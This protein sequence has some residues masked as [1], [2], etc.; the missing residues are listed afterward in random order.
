MRTVPKNYY[1]ALATMIGY[2]VGV[3]MFGLPFLVS[4][5]GVF[6]FV[7][8][9]LGLGAIQYLTHLIY[10]N[11]I[12]A[13]E[14]YHRLAGYAGIYLGKKGR[15]I[16][17]I[18]KIFGNIGGLL[19][20]III[21]GIFLHQ[22]LSPHF[23]G[24]EFFY[25]SLIFAFEAI[26]VF[27]GIRAIGRAELIMTVFL[28]LVVGLIIWRG[29]DVVSATNYV[30]FD[31]KYLLLPF[32]ATMVSLDG[33]GSLPIVA[34]LLNKDKNAV[35]S[36][37]R[38]GIL[39]PMLITLFFVL[40]IVGIS[41]PLTTQ[42]A[43][44]GV[45]LVLDDGVIFFSLIFGILTMITSFFGVAEAVKEMLWWDFRVNKN[46]AWAIA[47][48]VPYSLYVIGVKNLAVVISF[49]GAIGGGFCGIILILIYRKMVKMKD[50]TPLFS[51]R[52]PGKVIT[53]F[54]IALFISG[55]FYELFYFF[56]K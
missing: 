33:S 52:K 35:K 36:V 7:I 19:A 15:I 4:R 8:L 49:V 6:T 3:G 48:F 45:R 43:I 40:T 29:M 24:S 23:G 28:I 11:M 54:I 9:L 55:I 50:M 14:S 41:G 20:Y 27:F 26:V 34:K 16:V 37:V 38:F 31:W 42:D 44:S 17:F 32:G 10:A 5:A 53:S 21:T 56:T 18:A 2:M 47:V 22:L 13:T 39:I 1:Q 12:V 25:G 46:L 51:N 30:V